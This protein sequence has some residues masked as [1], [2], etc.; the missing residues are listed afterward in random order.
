MKDLKMANKF[1]QAT[2]KGPN[3]TITDTWL[4]NPSIINTLGGKDF[5]DLDPAQFKHPTKG[6]IVETAKNYYFESDDGLSKKWFGNV[7]LNPPYSDL[8]TWLE[9]MS[10]HGNGI[11]LCFLR[12]D[13]KKFQQH[14]KSATG[15]N[16]IK[17]RI[18]F[19][20][21]EGEEKGNGNAASCLIAWGEDNYQKIKKIDGICVRIDNS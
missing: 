17:G 1:Q 13:T 14:V 20:N 2:P 19:L 6:I 18:K 3:N 8:G 12:S 16:M 4:T 9:K 10:N 15:L 21:S 7:W 11:I 5:F